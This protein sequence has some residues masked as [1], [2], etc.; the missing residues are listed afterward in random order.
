MRN[1][2]RMLSVCNFVNIV[3]VS[4]KNEFRYFFILKCDRTFCAINKFGYFCNNNHK[5]I[6]WKNGK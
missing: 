3:V 6:I 5:I 1:E 4:I 2:E